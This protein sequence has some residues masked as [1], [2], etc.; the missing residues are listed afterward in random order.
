LAAVAALLLLLQP[1]PPLL[2]L[3]SEQW[4]VFAGEN[5]LSISCTM[6]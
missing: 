3:H 1:L 5:F 6:Q 4:R 2:P